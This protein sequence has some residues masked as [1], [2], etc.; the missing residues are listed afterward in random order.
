MNSFGIKNFLILKFKS[1]IYLLFIP[2]AIKW[3]LNIVF[4]LFL[5]VG[6][7]L[8]FILFKKYDY[9]LKLKKHKIFVKKI[10]NINQT[11]KYCDILIASSS[12]YKQMVAK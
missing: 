8:A 6:L 12:N 1:I 2:V 11:Q 10:K 7:I 4:S 9:C 5:I 3:H